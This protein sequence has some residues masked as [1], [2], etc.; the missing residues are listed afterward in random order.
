TGTAVTAVNLDLSGTPG[1]G[2]GDGQADSVIVNGTNGADNIK[3][4]GSATGVTVSGLA[5][6][7]KVTGSEAANDKL[8]INA[9]GGDDVVD[10]SGLKVGALALV[11]NGGAGNDILTGRLAAGED[12]D[13]FVWNP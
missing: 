2:S 8:T 4:S 1:S 6:T 11:I 10:A 5:A 13:T 12:V 7:V 9:Q 3:V